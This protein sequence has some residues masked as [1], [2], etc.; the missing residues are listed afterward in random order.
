[1]SLNRKLTTFIKGNQKQTQVAVELL[2]ECMDHWMGPSRDWTPLARLVT[3]VD[4]RMG[5]R[6]QRM[7][8]KALGGISKVT[9]TDAEYG[10]KYKASKNAGPSEKMAELRDLCSAGESIYSVAIDTWLDIEKAEPKKVDA[11]TYAKRVVARLEK[12]GISEDEFME[13]MKRAFI[14]ANAAKSKEDSRTLE[15]PLAAI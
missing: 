1:M 14:S 4:S 3:S 5:A 9:D 13:A 7:V 8:G 11:V 15:D 12:D 10:I 6:M 2:I